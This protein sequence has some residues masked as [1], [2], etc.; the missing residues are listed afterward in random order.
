MANDKK[1]AAPLFGAGWRALCTPTM[2][3]K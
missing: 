1:S 2:G 3:V